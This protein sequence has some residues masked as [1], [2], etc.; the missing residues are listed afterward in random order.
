MTDSRA[1]I[2]VLG[3]INMD[4]VV[5]APRLPAPGETVLG[6]TY[7]RH[8]GGKGAN[9]AAAAAKMGAHVRMI[10]MTGDDD[11]GRAM[12]DALAGAGVDTA[13]IESTPD[14]PTGVALITVDAAAENTI[15]VAS[16]ANALLTPDR[17]E[18]A[19]AIIQD[20]DVL[21]MQ[22]ES[23]IDAV[24]RAAA[25]ARDAD[26]TVILNAAPAPAEPL[27]DDLLQ[28]IDILI[29]NEGEAKAVAAG[30][31]SAVAF[32]PTRPPGETEPGAQTTIHPTIEP[33]LDLGPGAIIVTLGAQGAAFA[34]Q[35]EPGAAPAFNVEPTDTVG[36]GDAFCGAFACRWAELRASGQTLDRMSMVDAL[37]WACAAGALATT[38][39]GAIP[40]L[41]TRAETL[42]LLKTS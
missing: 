26:V 32:A 5:S 12:R 35:R 42:A 20:A 28:N 9:Q 3:S 6:A 19:A 31:G 25:I 34:W 2:C 1:R 33:L 38:R 22:L 21:L 16:G 14:A 40:S 13:A 8:P 24:A 41:P 27:P 30:A 7:A 10:G 37:S 36:A 15:V 23:P 39:P 18:A 4:L 11:N 17:A 29:V